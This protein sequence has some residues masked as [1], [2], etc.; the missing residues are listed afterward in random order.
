MLSVCGNSVCKMCTI[1]VE[2]CGFVYT[3]FIRAVRLNFSVV[4]KVAFTNKL[5][6]Y[7]AQCLYTRKSAYS[8]LL[9]TGFI[10]IPTTPTIKSII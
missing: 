7:L 10:H 6:H 1:I 2:T 9:F 5:S 3:F 8:P 4:G